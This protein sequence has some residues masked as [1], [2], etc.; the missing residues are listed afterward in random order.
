MSATRKPATPWTL[1]CE[2]TTESFAEA[3]D[4]NAGSYEGVRYLEQTAWHGRRWSA[5]VAYLRP[6][7]DRTNLVVRTGALVHTHTHMRAR[8]PTIK[9]IIYRVC[10]GW[11]TTLHAHSL[12]C[13]Q[14]GPGRARRAEPP[15]ERTTSQ[16]GR[17]HARLPSSNDT[18]RCVL[19]V[20]AFVLSQ[21]R[22]YLSCHPAMQCRISSPA[23]RRAPFTWTRT[24]SSGPPVWPQ[25]IASHSHPVPGH[26]RWPKCRF[27]HYGGGLPFR[28]YGGRVNGLCSCMRTSV[29]VGAR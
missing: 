18:S 24:A 17:Q 29:L 21:E 16:P 1:S 19:A 9:H 28:Y 3:P 13:T 2:S 15:C 4:Y 10:P 27:S 23:T 22:R 12:A 26:T 20:S 11:C 25:H 7:R 14:H 5:A 8:A 6:A